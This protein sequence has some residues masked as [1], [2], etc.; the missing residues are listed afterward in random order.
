MARRR[1]GHATASDGERAKRAAAHG[2]KKKKGRKG[3]ETSPEGR[4][5]PAEKNEGGGEDRRCR[6]ADERRR[7][8]GKE[9]RG[10]RAEENPH[11]DHPRRPESEGRENSPTTRGKWGFGGIPATQ[12]SGREGSCGGEASGGGGLV[13]RRL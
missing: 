3:R 2:E 10:I 7:H 12:S 5:W 13:R 1:R 9:R 4:Q 8:L 11:G 6:G